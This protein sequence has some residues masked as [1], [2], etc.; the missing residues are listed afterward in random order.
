VVIREFPYTVVTNNVFNWEADLWCSDNFGE[1]W[2]ATDN[3][4]GVWT[5]FWAGI[6][7]P[8][9]YVWHFKNE[10]DAVVFSLRWV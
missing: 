10:K 8:K 4:E 3:K 1:R 9:N 2:F 6:E 7:A 5:C